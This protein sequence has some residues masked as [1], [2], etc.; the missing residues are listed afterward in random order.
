[1]NEYI[2]IFTDRIYIKVLET[3]KLKSILA[4]YIALE[5]PNSKKHTTKLKAPYHQI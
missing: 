1:M 5:P 3:L 4:Y 2:I